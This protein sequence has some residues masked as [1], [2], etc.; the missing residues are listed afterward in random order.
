MLVANELR[1]T[2]FGAELLHRLFSQAKTQIMNR[3]T[4]QA[5]TKDS[6]PVEPANVETQAPCLSHGPT[7]SNEHLTNA[8]TIR[9]L[10]SAFTGLEGVFGGHEY[11]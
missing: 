11:V 3:K 7:Q 9:N 1:K 10:G 2:Y 6:Q 8:D 4:Q 5:A